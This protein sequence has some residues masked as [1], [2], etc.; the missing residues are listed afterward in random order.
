MARAKRYTQKELVKKLARDGRQ[1]T[2]GGKHQVKMIKEGRRPVT[3]PHFKG[4][5]LPVGLT[6]AILRQAEVED[7]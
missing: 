1:E 5:T 3:I 2:A 6:R 7:T 4:E